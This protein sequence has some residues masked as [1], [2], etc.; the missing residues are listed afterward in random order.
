MKVI[1]KKN[2]IALM[3]FLTISATSANCESLFT[4][5][6]MQSYMSEPKSLYGSVRARS[7]GD[8]VTI[9]LNESIKSVDNL[10]YD[11]ERSS[12]T[13]DNF[14]SLINKVLPGRPLND[15]WNQ[16]GGGNTVTSSSSTN[17]SMSFQNSITAQ[18]VQLLP[19]G[20]L[21]IQGKKTLVSANE[22]VDLLVSGVVDPRFINESGYIDSANVA[23]LQF[24]LNGKGSTSRLN[25][26]GIVNRV[27][28]YLF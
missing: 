10:S 25:S 17:R 18:V 5:S 4:M 7:V 21:M 19:N 13:T 9:L 23:N 14:S 2:L 6:A 16:Y 8:V 22:R 24:A 3:A 27:I 28:R 26:E 1:G 15:Q 20:N 11:S 12:L